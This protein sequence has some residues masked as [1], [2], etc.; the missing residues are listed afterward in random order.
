MDP[1]DLMAKVLYVT[2]NVEK[3][4]ADPK[5]WESLSHKKQVELHKIKDELDEYFSK[6]K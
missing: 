6:I 1:L 3:I 2:I 4:K 5:Y